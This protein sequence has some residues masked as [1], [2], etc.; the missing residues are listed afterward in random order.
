MSLE[1]HLSYDSESGVIT[2]S[3]PKNPR[4][5]VGDEAG[6]IDQKSGYKKINFNYKSYLAHRVAWYLYYGEWPEGM[7]DHINRD[8]TDNKI[9]NLR[10]AS[11]REN[12][13]NAVHY[14]KG[15][16]YEIS[17][18]KWLSQIH[19]NGRNKKL[20]RFK[21]EIEAQEAYLQAAERID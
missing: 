15:A 17:S 7:I 12:L 9:S 19:I 3:N 1:Q 14:N 20:G 10:L 5:K 8:R 16:T 21:S 6:C 11:N 2:W 4:L 13:Q 18:G